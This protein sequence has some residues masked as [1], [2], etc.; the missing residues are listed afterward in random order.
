MAMHFFHY[1]AHENIFISS[2]RDPL[3]TERNG[4]LRGKLGTG[5]LFV[6]DKF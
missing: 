5:C 1:L 4:K 2:F 3:R 6:K